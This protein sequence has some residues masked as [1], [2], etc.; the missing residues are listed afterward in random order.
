[1]PLYMLIMVVV[2]VA[3]I[4]IMTGLMGTFSGQNLGKVAANPDVIEVPGGDGETTFTVTVEDTE[5]RPIEGATVY[6]EGEGVT[7]ATKTGSDGTATFTV[8]PDL[9]AKAVGELNVRVTH[10]GAFGGQSRGTSILLVAA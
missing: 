3:A 4:G 1:M 8:H 5:G 7:T 10:E 6:I 9:G 2:V